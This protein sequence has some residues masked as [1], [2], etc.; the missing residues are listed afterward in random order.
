MELTMALIRKA[1]GGSGFG[2]YWWE[3][4]GDAVEVDGPTADEILRLRGAGFSLVSDVL[5]DSTEEPPIWASSVRDEPAETVAEAPTED[6]EGDPMDGA[7][8]VAD[9]DASDVPA[10]SVAS[11]VA[12][13]G[14][15]VDRARAAL[16]AE[17]D[18]RIEMRPTLV[19]QMNAII[20]A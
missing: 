11:I 19:Q 2:D 17:A 15:D 10:G 7:E 5:A 14:A 4:D 13:V 16:A 3:R 12:W 9:D 20:D 1:Q 18:R 8:V 6:P